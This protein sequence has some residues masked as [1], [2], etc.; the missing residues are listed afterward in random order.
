MIS[1]QNPANAPVFIWGLDMGHGE[2]AES[3]FEEVKSLTNK[4]FSLS[5]FDVTDWNEQFSPWPAPAVFGKED[6]GGK[7]RDTLLFL[8]NDILLEIKSIFPG[9]EVFLTGY[10][11]AGLFSLWALYESNKFNGAVC[12]SSLMCIQNKKVKENNFLLVFYLFAILCP[13]MACS[14]NFEPYKNLSLLQK[15]LTPELLFQNLECLLPNV[16]RDFNRFME[17]RT[18]KPEITITEYYGHPELDEYTHI[19]FDNKEPL[20]A[21]IKKAIKYTKKFI[22]VYLDWYISKITTWC[23]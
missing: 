13:G 19:D 7:G 21:E 18:N 4:D 8:E 23:R 14:L 15:D 11:L 3:L 9:S 17:W 6:F 5:V 10:S 20:E 16:T 12:C 2:T 1:T 22:P